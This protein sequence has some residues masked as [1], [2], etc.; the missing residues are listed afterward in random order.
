VVGE[1]VA[2]AV[3]RGAGWGAADP[4]VRS[5]KRS[6]RR[7]RRR[8]QLAAAAFV[9]PLLVFTLLVFVV[10][11]GDMLRRSFWN[12]ELAAAWPNVRAAM[13]T[14]HAEGAHGV[15][16][17]PVFAA[18]AEDLRKTY[19]S[20]PLAT[21]ARRLN[22]DLENGR[23]LVI[24]TGRRVAQLDGPKG[25]WTET[26]AALDPRWGAHETWAAIDRARVP[27]T[28]FFLL[29]ALDL[30][31]DEGQIVRK[32]AQQA[33][34]L[35]VLGRTFSISLTVTLACLVLGFPVAYA[36]ASQP[37]SRAN[38][39]LMLVL[40]PFWTP[41]LV[42][43]AAWV[44]VLQEN[45]LANQLLAGLGLIDRPLRLIYN[46]TGV[47]VA[48]THVLMPFMILPLYSVMKGVPP[49]LMRAALSL[50]APPFT[51]FRR[52]YL[53]QVMPGVA[54]GALLVFILALGYYITPA[55]VG[56]GADQMISAFVAFNTTDTANWSLAAALGTVLLAATFVLF[57]VATRLG[58]R[59]RLGVLG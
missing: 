53:P 52:V 40:L 5:L 54:A 22:Y 11:I 27:L 49:S 56:G 59:Y 36:I 9:T 1:P 7:S 16:P 57:A 44:V 3:P 29:A 38:L 8:R 50:G 47:L 20:P 12:A 19:G 34:Y 4:A 46:R 14:W 10:P 21:A 35:E 42:R 33:I 2:L 24:N 28:D 23:S 58:G 48:M 41:L 25:T 31:R 15:P 39:L 17:E 37:P 30:Q 45:G 55:L 6:L 13:T 51:A 18:L 43:T 26:L 32:P